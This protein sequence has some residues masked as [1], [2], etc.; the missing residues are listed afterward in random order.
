MAISRLSARAIQSAR[1]E[2]TEDAV[3]VDCFDASDIS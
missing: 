1:G 2:D 3:D